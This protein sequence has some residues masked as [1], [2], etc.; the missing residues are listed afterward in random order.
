MALMTLDW[1]WRQH[2]QLAK[3][4]ERLKL[5]GLVWPQDSHLGTC[6]KYVCVCVLGRV[7]ALGFYSPPNATTRMGN[8]AQLVSDLLSTP[9]VKIRF[10]S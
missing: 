1:L 4:T 5:L 7:D 3:K 8:R 6:G 10:V 9:N 2:T